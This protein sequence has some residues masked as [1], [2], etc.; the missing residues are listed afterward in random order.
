LT[1]VVVPIFLIL[2]CCFRQQLGLFEGKNF[3]G[4]GG[5]GG[6]GIMLP[7]QEYMGYAALAG[8]VFWLCSVVACHSLWVLHWT[9]TGSV[10]N[11][12]WRALQLTLIIAGIIVFVHVVAGA[13]I[14]YGTMTGP[15]QPKNGEQ[16]DK[17][18]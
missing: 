13:A 10:N 3:I 16:K 2:A 9:R 15:Q 11:G 8:A 14:I 18:K 1:V 4:G 7:K 6:V 12:D 17:M 5:H